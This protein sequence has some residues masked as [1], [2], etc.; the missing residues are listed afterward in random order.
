MNEEQIKAA[1]IVLD[2][3]EENNSH[4]IGRLLTW[5]LF[6]EEDPVRDELRFRTWLVAKQFEEQFYAAESR[7]QGK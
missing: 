4:T 1:R 6:G 5:D 7:G 2:Y 3:L